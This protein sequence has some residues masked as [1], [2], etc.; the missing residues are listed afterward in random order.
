MVAHEKENINYHI[1][2]VISQIEHFHGERKLRRKDGTLL[3]VEVTANLITY[4]GRKVICAVA[5]DISERKRAEKALRESEKKYSMLVESSLTG[6]YI[7]QDGKIAVTN[8]KCAEIYG[9][10]RNELEGMET[11]K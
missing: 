4:A 8:N 9:Y 5:R 3:D 2:Q 1:E 10:S 6:I 11:R 7:D